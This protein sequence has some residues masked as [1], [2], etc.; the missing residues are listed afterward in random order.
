VRL[1][2]DTSVVLSACAS[3]SGASRAIFGAA[4]ANGWVLVVTP[5]VVAEVERNLP[6]FSLA[7]GTA[8]R[9]L[10]PQLLL[11]GDVLTLRLPVVFPVQK[12][13]PVLFGALAWSDV[14]L[15]LDGEDFCKLLGREFYALPVLKPGQFLERERTAGRFMLG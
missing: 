2:L 10:H 4:V 12:D 5:Y 6:K 11:M 3:T 15:T 13:R 7:T 8:W 9:E 14:L 1:F